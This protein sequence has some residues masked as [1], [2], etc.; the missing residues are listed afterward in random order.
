MTYLF[1]SIPFQAEIEGLIRTV[2]ERRHTEIPS[3]Q[4]VNFPSI[5]H[6]E[7]KKLPFFTSHRK[8]IIFICEF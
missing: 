8:R 7:K 5:F 1:Y 2:A 4:G 3:P 6:C